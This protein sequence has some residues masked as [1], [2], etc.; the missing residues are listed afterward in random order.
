MENN[1]L[2]NKYGLHN[3]EEVKQ[4]SSRTEI[5]TGEK[6]PQNPADQIENYL[7]RFHEI[8]D[9]K[10]GEDKEMGMQALKKVLHDK[11]II[12]EEEV[13]ESYFDNQKRIAREQGHGDIEV[14]N[15]M[16][17]Q[18]ME[19][20]ISDQKGT[21]DNW[22]DYLSSSD[23]TYP[24]WLKYYAFR[25][26]LGMGA[27][28]KEKK[29]FG[30]RS[31]GT[32]KP[33][34]DINREALA[35]VLDAIEKKNNKEKINQTDEEFE[36]L[37]QG[38]NF[39][40][41]Y[42]Y[43]IDKVTPAS[44]EQITVTEGKWVKYNKGQDHM[45]LVESLQGHGTGWCTAGESTAKTQLSNGDFYVYYSKDKDGKDKIPR[46]AIRME[47][48]KIAEVRGIGPDQNMDPYI[49]DVVKEKMTE[50]PDGKLYE[51]KSADM[52]YLTEIENKIKKGEKL[53]KEELE[54]IYEVKGSIEGFGYQRDPRIKELINNRNKKEDIPII[55]ECSKNQIA[56]SVSGLNENTKAYIGKWNPEIMKK[57]PDTIE[58]LYES[59]PEKKILK[60]NIELT[61]KNPKEYTQ[62]LLSE[63]Y[64]I[65]NIAQDLLNKLEP[66]KQKENIDIVSFSVE[67]LGFPNGARLQEVYD[68]AKEFGLELC[69]PQVGPELRLNYKNQPYDED[70]TIATEPF[71]GINY[72]PLLFGVHRSNSGSWISD[73]HG[74][75]GLHGRGD[76]RY[77][78]RFR[79]DTQ[80]L[81]S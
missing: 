42:A 81:E 7:A 28:D 15:E 75:L 37:L 5:R 19:V 18:L 12:K 61:T 64:K 63:G 73:I 6:V 33:F 13:P 71:V 21:L 22:I 65:E 34:P 76:H 60:R 38:E 67:Q 2:K 27:Y 11:F 79:K 47:N 8:V 46:V 14:T 26:V 49:G 68:K 54:F 70:L 41:L 57:I 59:F 55:F 50:F 29:E 62:E 43:A 35:Y 9:R 30:K 39:A 80:H 4:Q 1:F 44:V 31:K 40:K 58:Y 24:D 25:S 51:K 32:T 3:S 56:H 72:F 45:P 36:K 16:K 74:Q 17:K 77:V 66:I 10:N 78:F 23:A 52:K 53:N 20:V 48:D 69:P